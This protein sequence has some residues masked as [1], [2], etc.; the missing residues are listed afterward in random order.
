MMTHAE[1]AETAQALLKFISPAD[2]RL[3]DK[4]QG[5]RVRL[6]LGVYTDQESFSNYFISGQNSNRVSRLKIKSRFL[7]TI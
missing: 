7:A 4:A 2:A 3:I 1:R 6:R 5:T